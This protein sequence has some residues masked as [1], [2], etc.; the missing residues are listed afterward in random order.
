MRW[1]KEKEAK[2][3]KLWEEGLP[4]AVIGRRLGVS[5]N[6]VVGK[7]HQMKLESR[8]HPIVRVKK[9]RQPLSAKTRGRT[10]PRILQEL[11]SKSPAKK[12]KEKKRPSN[13][14]MATRAPNREGQAPKGKCLWPFGDPRSDAY[15][16]CDE[17]KLLGSKPYCEVH[18]RKAHAQT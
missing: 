4:A 10:S 7:A 1:T 13:S 12:T 18:D 14:K 5:K 11:R 6:A 16:I 15:R 8:P 17:D 2:L 9:L 3:K